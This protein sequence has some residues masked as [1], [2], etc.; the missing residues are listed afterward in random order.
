MI[1]G[2]SAGKKTD[3]HISAEGKINSAMLIIVNYVGRN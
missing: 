3:V 1:L 2:K